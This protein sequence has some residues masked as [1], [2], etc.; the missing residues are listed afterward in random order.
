M[1]R[2]PPHLGAERGL[3][4]EIAV[5]ELTVLPRGDLTAGDGEARADIRGLSP[6]PSPGVRHLAAAGIAGRMRAPLQGPSQH[7][8]SG[9]GGQRLGGGVRRRTGARARDP[10][11]LTCPWCRCSRGGPGSGSP[12]AGSPSGYSWPAP[13]RSAG[14]GTER[15]M[16]L[17][18]GQRASLPFPDRSPPRTL[19]GHLVMSSGQM[20]A[21]LEAGS[22]QVLE[23]EV[24]GGKMWGLGIPSR[25]RPPASTPSRPRPLASTPTGDTNY[26]TLSPVFSESSAVGTW[27]PGCTQ[28]R[29]SASGPNQTCPWGAPYHP[30][31]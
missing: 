10:G 4:V 24:G 6:D 7:G 9:Q 18:S 31:T 13:C 19:T 26:M 29:K 11:R 20:W 28:P 27:G 3:L 22:S 15:G 25:P 30:A 23:A 5:H 2:A 1:P 12:C 8:R 14:R 21:P 17:C 16:G